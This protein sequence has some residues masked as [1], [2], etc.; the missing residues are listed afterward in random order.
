M[1]PPPTTTASKLRSSRATRTFPGRPV[2]FTIPA[3]ALP[4]SGSD[5]R[6][7][8][9]PSQPVRRAPVF[10]SHGSPAVRDRSRCAPAGAWII[11]RVSDDAI[12]L[13]R[14]AV[15]AFNEQGADPA[16]AK[17]TPPGI[18]ASEPEIVPIRA[19]L[20]GITYTGATALDDFW[21]ANRESWARL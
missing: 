16:A 17:P 3:P 21:A 6:R 13:A 20:E 11:R 7:H 15:D 12:T 5:G 4:G 14:R 19:A 9:P 18:Y 1:T 2:R 8:Q 10:V